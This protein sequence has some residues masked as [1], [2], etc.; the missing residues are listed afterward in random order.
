MTKKRFGKPRTV[1]PRSASI[2]PFHTSARLVP[3]APNTRAPMGMS[4]T[5]KPVPKTMASTSC[6]LPSAATSVEPRSS[7]R[8]EETT[9]VLA[10]ASAG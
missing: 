4:V 9:S 2:P 8:P 1:E 5:W 6:S 7:R 10:A 3:S